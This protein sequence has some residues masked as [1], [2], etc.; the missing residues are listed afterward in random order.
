MY[1]FKRQQVRVAPFLPA[2]FRLGFGK[3]C[4]PLLPGTSSVVALE[5]A[6]PFFVPFASFGLG[7]NAFPG[8]LSLSAG[9]TIHARFG[10]RSSVDRDL[11][12]QLREQLLLK[13]FSFHNLL[14]HTQRPSL[15]QRNLHPWFCALKSYPVREPRTT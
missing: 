15:P 4:S 14:F 11:Q 13:C 3:P 1:F 8:R 10:S 6:V 9:T 5:S 7:A 2:L 12:L